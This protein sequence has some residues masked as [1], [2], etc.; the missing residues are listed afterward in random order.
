M[1]TKIYNAYRVPKNKI[2][3]FTAGFRKIVI[4]DAVKE[5]NS[6]ISRYDYEKALVDMYPS[7][8]AQDR[9]KAKKNWDKIAPLRSVFAQMMHVSDKGVRDTHNFDTSFNVWFDGKWAYI[10]PYFACSFRK[11]SLILKMVEKLGGGDYGYYDNTDRPD[12]ISSRQWNSR[13]KT[14]GRIC[15]DD[16]EDWDTSRFTHVV[17]EGKSP[18]NGFFQLEEAIVGIDAREGHW[19]TYQGAN[20]KDDLKDAEEE[21]RLKRQQEHKNA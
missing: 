8:D 9:I 4:N 5:I 11:Q 15:L 13:K 14:W 2:P 17:I 6:L 16:S 20:L 1:S 12:G 7:K 18:Y 10:I 21:A 19:I 3:E